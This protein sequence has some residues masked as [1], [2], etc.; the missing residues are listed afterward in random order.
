MELLERQ[1]LGIVGF[2]A[3]GRLVAEVLG[4]HFDLKVHDPA[5]THATLAD[6]SD[7]AMGPLQD[8]ARCDVVVL[9]VPVAAMRGLCMELGPMLAE[10]TLLVD[11]GSVKMHPMAIMAELIPAHIEIVG[12]HPLFG[13]QSI[14]N[15][16]AGKK[17][18]LCPV[19]GTRWR[20][21]SAFLRRLGLDVIVTTAREHDQELATVQGLTHLIAKVI[22]EMGP[23]PD[24]MTTASF[25]CLVDAVNMVKDDSAAVLDAIEASNPYAAD[26]RDTFFERAA[27]LRGQF[28]AQST[29]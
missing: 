21:V 14:G 20:W 25:D 16:V 7:I 5:Y 27:H 15:T 6:G 24:R 11:V 1:R 18:A 17:I 12:T 9:A 10:G 2:G 3:F 19:R 8:V 22:V 28:D 4:P 23:L 13:P 26:V 29:P